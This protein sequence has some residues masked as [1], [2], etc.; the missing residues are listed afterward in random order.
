MHIEYGLIQFN[1]VQ[2]VTTGGTQIDIDF[3]IKCF[4]KSIFTVV[5]VNNEL[6]VFIRPS[7]LIVYFSKKG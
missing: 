1:Y 2:I 4:W 5:M 7:A 3:N 6:A